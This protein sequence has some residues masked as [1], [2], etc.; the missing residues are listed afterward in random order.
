MKIQKPTVGDIVIYTDVSG[1]GSAAIVVDV[2]A[3]R[4]SL[5]WLDVHP[6]AGNSEHGETSRQFRVCA[7]YNS[8]AD[9][10]TWRWRPF[11]TSTIEVPQ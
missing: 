8:E 4:P 9:P 6:T 3:Q 1:R 5:L 7:D 11:N 10:G 2:A